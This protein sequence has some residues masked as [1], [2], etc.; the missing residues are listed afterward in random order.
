[1]PTDAHFINDGLAAADINQA[2]FGSC[3]FL[4]ALSSLAQKLPQHSSLRLKE[5]AV[6]RVIQK[7]FNLSEQARQA[8][9]FRF[10]VSF[11]FINTDYFN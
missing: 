3:W 9:V 4:A 11:R 10:K 7:E 5:V 2:G 1:M 6:Q 8:G